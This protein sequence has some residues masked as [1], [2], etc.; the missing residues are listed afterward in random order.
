MNSL[1]F[2]ATLMGAGLV[3]VDPNVTTLAPRCHVA[4]VNHEA[5][6]GAAQKMEI[7]IRKK[8]DGIVRYGSTGKVQLQVN[9]IS[10][11]PI[12]APQEHRRIR[13]YYVVTDRNEK[14]LAAAICAQSP[15][16]CANIIANTAMR[17][18]RE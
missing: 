13:T 11:V 1:Y 17:Y 3:Q 12:G 4:V 9:L 8:I 6:S 16:V 18:C 15:D 10:A 5:D 7:E 2:A 14:F